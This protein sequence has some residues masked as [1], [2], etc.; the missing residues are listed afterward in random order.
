LA[1][2]QGPRIGILSFGFKHGPP[3]EADLVFDVRFL[4]NPYFVAELK[5]HSGLEAGVAN[6]VLENEIAQ[7]FIKRLMSLLCFLIPQYE[8]E[9]KTYLT[10]G[11]G[12]TGGHHRSVAVAERL[13]E[14]LR[15]D[16]HHISVA[17][18][19]L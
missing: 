16:K 6:Y 9:G 17:H 4:A 1:V 10:I 3:V 2:C 15:Q 11:I 14:L 12:C 18:R 8:A 7:E 13:A 5:E 19:D